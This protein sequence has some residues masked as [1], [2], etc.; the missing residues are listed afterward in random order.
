MAKPIIKPGDMHW[1]C[2]EYDCNA[3][4]IK[5]I[6]ILKYREEDIKKMKKKAANK[7]EFKELLNREM[8]WRFWSKCEHELIIVKEEDGS[9]WL[10]PWVGC[11]NPEEV[12]INVS[13][14]AS[15]D[16]K[17]FAEFYIS[18]QRYK[19]KAKI[20]VYNQLHWTWD[21][22]VDYCWNFRHKWQRKNLGGGRSDEL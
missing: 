10:T 15:F 14:D 17:R 21:E 20:D 4:V 5:Y 9:I 11:R 1:Y 2:K 19:N 16:W 7:E 12:K 6:D 22:F 8:M 3:N 13:D 18:G